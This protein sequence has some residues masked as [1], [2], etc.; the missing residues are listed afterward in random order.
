MELARTLEALAGLQNPDGG[1]PYQ[2]GGPS[3]TESTSL[4]VLALQAHERAATRE[5]AGRGVDWLLAR[6]QEDGGW[7][8]SQAVRQSTWVTAPALLA[9]RTRAPGA[10][11]AR[12][13]NWL[14]ASTGRE[15]GW[16]ERLRALLMGRG[17]EAAASEGWPWFP[18]AAAWVEPTALTLLSLGALDDGALRQ[19]RQQRVRAGRDFLLARQCRDGG[20]NHGST[21]ALGYDSDS[22]PESTGWALLALRNAGGPALQ[23]GLTRARQHLASTAGG[24]ARS[25]LEMGLAAHGVWLPPDSAPPPAAKRC[26]AMSFWL[27]AQAAREGRHAL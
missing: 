16:V 10:S 26:R 12:A 13:A 27:L 11:V 22:Y 9:V 15:S 20:W 1:W 6:Q 19:S 18:E 21:R 23:R 25:L 5:A 7:R 4:A 14:L 17:S 3:W 24:E 8:P 2:P